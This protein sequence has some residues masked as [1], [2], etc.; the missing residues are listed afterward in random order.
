[1][2]STK[3]QR[4]QRNVAL[5]LEEI[6]PIEDVVGEEL[7]ILLDE[8][9]LRRHLT[10]DVF[11][12]RGVGELDPVY[13]ILRLQ[14][15]LWDEGKVPDLVYEGASPSTIYRDSAGKKQNYAALGVREYVQFDPMGGML[16]P[17]LQVFR[18]DEYGTYEP[19][20]PEADGSVR[21]VTLPDY[22]W[23]IGGYLLRLRDRATGQLVPTQREQARAAKAE[24]QDAKAQA[25]VAKIE[26]QA[27]EAHAQAAEAHVRAAEAHAQAAEIHAQAEA[28]RAS[29]A[30]AENARLREQL[31]RLREDL[32]PA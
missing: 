28:A 27:A 29:A 18:L 25:R 5:C 12:A 26:A 24:A 3:H 17:R 4:A 16:S 14:Y 23:V 21:C 11:V 22:D 31:A 32:P 20:A 7:M 1:M 13:G 15:R 19:V 8:N 9:N 2:P 6:L 30:E 10:P